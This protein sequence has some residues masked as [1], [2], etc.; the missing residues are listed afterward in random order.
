MLHASSTEVFDAFVDAETGRVLQKHNM[1]KSAAGDARV[2]DRFPGNGPGG[3]AATKNLVTLGYLTAGATTLDGPNVRTF[4]DLDDN[5]NQDAGEVHLG[6]RRVLRVHFSPFPHASCNASHLCGW[7]ATAATRTAN[8]EQNGVQAFYLA[9]RFHEYLE[10]PPINFTRPTATSRSI[11]GDRLILHTDDGANTGPDSQ[12]LDN[13][14][15]LTPPDGMSPVMQ[16]YLWAPDDFRADQRRRRR[17]DPVPRV[18]TRALGRLVTDAAGVGALNTAQSGAMGEG[19][20]T[21]REGLHR[22]PSS[23]ARHAA[24]GEVDMGDYLDLVPQLDP[25]ARRS[26]AR[27][28]R[29]PGSAR[30][31]AAGSGRLHVRRL[32]PVNGEPEVHGD[33]EIWA[34]TLW[35]LRTG[36]ARRRAAADHA[37]DA[38]VAAGAVVPR[39][40]QRDPAGRRRRVAGPSDADLQVFANRGMGFFAAADRLD[41][42]RADRGRSMPPAGGPRG[43]STG[44]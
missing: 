43:R 25:H 14:N 31:M 19:G 11:D 16:M 37:G 12:H 24:A 40:A 26:T 21:G 13:A 8:R 23:R 3:A 10:E 7:N 1:V 44:T 32:R 18:H 17:V 15:M 33:G 20:A 30:R 34:Q 5:D 41:R 39:H 29:P 28:A 9:N 36:S 4:S 35:D 2:W 6:C 22:Q 27:S 42:R 38:A